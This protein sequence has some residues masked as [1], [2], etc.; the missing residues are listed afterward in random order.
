M[1]L[2]MESREEDG[3]EG[4][5]DDDDVD[6]LAEEASTKGAE[7]AD[8]VKAKDPKY[9]HRS[10]IERIGEKTERSIGVFMVGVCVCAC[11][12]G[13]WKTG[14]AGA[15]TSKNERLEAFPLG[16]CTQM[17]AIGAAVPDADRDGSRVCRCCRQFCGWE[18]LQSPSVESMTS[19]TLSLFNLSELSNNDERRNTSHHDG[20]SSD[21]ADDA[22]RLQHTRKAVAPY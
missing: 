15:R 12:I 7:K 18:P 11:P 20:R 16:A 1:S 13:L 4:E 10:K 6:A 17:R 22:P 14:K 9:N 21:G 5:D 3:L 19:L 8:A 2:Q